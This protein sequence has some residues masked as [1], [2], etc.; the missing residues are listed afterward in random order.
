MEKSSK[1]GKLVDNTD[2]FRLL[3]KLKTDQLN[4]EKVHVFG[5][6][7]IC[8]TDSLGFPTPSNLSP[9]ELV[10]DATQ[11]FIPLWEKNMTLNWRFNE[12]SFDPF[13]DPEAARRAVFDLLGRS[14]LLWGEAVPIRFSYN[15]DFYD[16]EITMEES[17][18]CNT[19]GCVLAQSFFPDSGRHALVIY[20]KLV[21]QTPKEQ[22]DT[23]AHELGHIFGLRH[24]FAKIAESNW[25]SEMFGTHHPFSIM[26][27]GAQSEMTTEDIADLYRLYQLAWSKQLTHI[28]G[29][30]IRFVRPYH[31]T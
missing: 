26:N 4:K 2:S 6:K 3:P 10:L 25:P 18:R 29:T 27:Y 30:P 31:Y 5:N 20:P 15:S 9:L 22:I 21:Q 11:G 12:L 1:E 24:F 19:N 17:D 8:K 14:I 7:V 23:L 28:N 13:S 16:F